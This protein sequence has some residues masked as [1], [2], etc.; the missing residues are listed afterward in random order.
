MTL[1]TLKYTPLTTSEV[2]GQEKALIK[3]KSF[4]TNYKTQKKKAAFVYGALGTGKTSSIYALAKELNY[5]I[6]E[7]NSSDARNKDA[8]QSFLSSTLGQMS[9]FMRPKIILIDEVDNLS[10]R[11]DRGGINILAKALAKAK[12]PVILT[13]NDPFNSKHK[14]LCKLSEMIEFEKVDYKIIFDHLKKICGIENINFEEKAL[15]SIARQCDGDVRSALIDINTLYPLGDI[16]YDSLSGLSNRKRTD[17][18]F[19][20]LN[21]I[22]K[23]NSAQ[24][25]Q[26]AF[27]TTDVNPD[28]I[29][30][31]LDQNMPKEYTDPRA[32]AKAYEH[33]SRADI[34][35][36][37]IMRRQHWR[38][39]VYVFDL[40]SVGVSLSKIEKNTRFIDYKRSTR[41]LMMW[42]S[43]NKLLKK[44]EIASKL[45]QATHTSS[46]V[47]FK[48]VHF[49]QHIFRHSKD[50]LI[51]KELDLTDEQSAWLKKS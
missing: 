47:A 18:I 3:L 35:K 32:L 11:Y 48:Q 41:P 20:A 37:R 4:V 30:L 29:L 38:Y 8:M 31:W 25:A 49:L 42:M 17:T 13:A 44:R 19:H 34:F 45:A 22:F 43:K 23:A 26:T 40:L 16:T 5:D 9:L 1:F 7:I 12:F 51:S 46:K 39:L 33:M 27:E 10:G 36:R 21:I 14:A 28:E 6:V 2:I 24:V 15:K 50:S